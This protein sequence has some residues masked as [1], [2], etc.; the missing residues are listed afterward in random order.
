MGDVV[1]AYRE[2]LGGVMGIKCGEEGIALRVQGGLDI[3]FQLFS[4][5]MCRSVIFWG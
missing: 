2:L 3:M 5:E 1:L 4:N